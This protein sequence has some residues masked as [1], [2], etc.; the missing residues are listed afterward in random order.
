MQCPSLAHSLHQKATHT[1]SAALVL[2]LMATQTVSTVL[3]GPEWHTVSVV[4]ASL[5]LEL[6]APQT[7]SAVLPAFVLALKKAIC[8]SS[9]GCDPKLTSINAQL[10][11]IKA[12]TAETRSEIRGSEV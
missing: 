12:P 4:L 2:H 8:S 1:V 11:Y 10:I 3:P 5:V 6:K 7:V 9:N